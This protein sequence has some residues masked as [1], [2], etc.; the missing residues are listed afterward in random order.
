[1]A[2]KIKIISLIALLVGAIAMLSL[3]V[4]AATSSKFTIIGSLSFEVADKTLYVKDVRLANEDTLSDSGETLSTFSPGFVNGNF[5]LDLGQVVTE[6]NTGTLTL[7]FDVIN[8]SDEAYIA[9]ANS[10]NANLNASATGKISIGT[11]SPA[12]IGPNS[13]ISGTIKLILTVNSNETIDLSCVTVLI[14]SYIDSSSR[15][16]SNDETLGTTDYIGTFEEGT[17]V[18]LTIDI[19]KDVEFLGWASDLAGNN[20]LY[21]YPEYTFTV[22]TN[23][24]EHFYAIFN[25]IETS[26][27]IYQI[28]T[29]NYNATVYGAKSGA[30]DLI[31]PSVIYINKKLC[32]VTAF[33][34]GG[35]IMDAAFYNNDDIENVK[36]NSVLNNISFQEC[37]NLKNVI[38]P[39]GLTSIN[40]RAF[41]NCSN[42]QNVNIPNSVTVI[43]DRAFYGCSSLTSITIPENVD[44]IEYAAFCKCTNLTEINYNATNITEFDHSTGGYGG[45]FEDVGTAGTGVIFNIGSNVE[46]L[47]ESLFYKISGSTSTAVSDNI[48]EVKFFENSKITE[49]KNYTFGG[50]SNLKTINLPES[51]TL[52]G[53]GVFSGCSSLNG[54][55]IPNGITEIS[56]SLF[57]NCFSLTEIIIPANVNIINN[58]AFYNC[59]SLNSITIPEE[60]TIIG[61][62]AFYNCSSLQNLTLPNKVTQL[63][64]DVFKNCTKLNNIEIKQDSLLDTIGAEA[65]SGCTSL[66]SI[67][68]P[69]GVTV[70]ENN[71][72]YN[73]SS[74]SQVDLSDNLSS[75]NSQSFYGC[76]KLNNISLPNTLT[77]IG[78]SAFLDCSSLTDIEI[79]NGVTRL[80]Y[81]SFKGCSLLAEISLSE[82]LNYI[83]S[84]VFENCAS[85]KSIEIPK[86]VVTIGSRA[87]SG[88]TS[89]TEINFNAI[90]ITSFS[91]NTNVS[92]FQNAGI[93]GSGITI[94]VGAEVEEIPNYFMS[95]YYNNIVQSSN[96]NI[97]TINFVQNGNLKKIG[98]YAF[99]KCENL[100]TVNNISNTLDTINSSAF[101]YCRSLVSLTIPEN[102]IT[103]GSNAFCFC[104]SL[105]EI[106]Y[107]ATNVSSYSYTYSGSTTFKGVFGDAGINSTGITL[108]IGSNVVSIPKSFLAYAV[109]TTSGSTHYYNYSSSNANLKSVNF[110]AN[111]NLETI[112]DHAFFGNLNIKSLNLPN[113]LKVIDS[114][115][116][117]G[118]GLNSITIPA[119]VNKINSYAFYNCVNLDTIIFSGQKNWKTSSGIVKYVD[120]SNPTQ[121]AIWLT[122]NVD[123]YSRYWIPDPNA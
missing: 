89:L 43:N 64:D 74:L 54:I 22:Q 72:F 59:S 57:Y 26:N 52:M 27:V 114:S 51:L 121:N 3:G 97:K 107:N 112:G 38:L 100:S 119:S 45:I 67:L 83:G 9:R 32:L 18:T 56:T 53:N 81:S 94:N 65:F 41:S 104:T 1:M 25:D 92:V 85:L 123:Y 28:Q 16:H 96:A 91:Y 23:S 42:L 17:E 80:E 31:I 87:L 68:I 12:E 71:T 86:N 76:S 106:N 101:A 99:Y 14:E 111:G 98:T 66:I 60:V 55:E 122:S 48:V 90:K 30:T 50:C 44:T 118:C 7:Y 11:I 10:T 120:F 113:K 73:C 102:V 8:C 93:E 5:R 39:E 61:D 19:K 40:S 6:T 84:Y 24:P 58:S 21:T 69:N 105:T 70:I 82:N 20:I 88:C 36:I 103:I 110:V 47:P 117:S 108:N 95:Y 78:N 34:T 4:W 62:S 15:V 79:P 37:S 116:F 2:I 109:V 49:L 33:K 63:G 29:D 115:A 75:I 77:I 35:L 46:T 13:E